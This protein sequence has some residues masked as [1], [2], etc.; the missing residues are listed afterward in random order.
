MVN[1]NICEENNYK[2][3]IH[4]DSIL[5]N[6]QQKV[7]PPRPLLVGPSVRYSYGKKVSGHRHFLLSKT[8]FKRDY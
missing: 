7:I 2:L 1:G 3:M 8:H 4:R 6:I 5:S